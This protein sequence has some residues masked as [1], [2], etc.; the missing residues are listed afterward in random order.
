MLWAPI[1]TSVT[2]EERATYNVKPLQ[3]LLKESRMK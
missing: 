2:D 1:D 3:E